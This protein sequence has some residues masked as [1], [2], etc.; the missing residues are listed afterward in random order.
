MNRKLWILRWWIWKDF[1]LIPPSIMFLVISMETTISFSEIISL[2]KLINWRNLMITIPKIS[3]ILSKPRIKRLN[4]K[5]SIISN[6][7]FLFWWESTM[8]RQQKM[9]FA[10]WWP[11]TLSKLFLIHKS[12]KITNMTSIARLL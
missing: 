7:K 9:T 10:K 3:K 12:S 8:A 5:N 4:R 6:L 11:L 2:V 1:N